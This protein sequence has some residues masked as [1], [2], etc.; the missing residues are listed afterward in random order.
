MADQS[1]T[2]KFIKSSL[3]RFIKAVRGISSCRPPMEM[4]RYGF[5]KST[6]AGEDRNWWSP[7]RVDTPMSQCSICPGSERTVFGQTKHQ[8]CPA[9]SYKNHSGK[10]LFFDSSSKV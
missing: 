10:T 9:D 1:A 5:L 4:E 7:S 2:S 3:E 8:R 6:R